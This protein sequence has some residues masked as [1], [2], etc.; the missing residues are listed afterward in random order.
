MNLERWAIFVTVAQTV[1]LT[2]AAAKLGQ[3]R[4]SREVALLEDELG[5]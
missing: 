2:A 3:S 4:V 1:A 5:G